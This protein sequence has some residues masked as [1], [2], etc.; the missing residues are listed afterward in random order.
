VGAEFQT[1]YVRRKDMY[2]VLYSYSERGPIRRLPFKSKIRAIR[3]ARIL[4]EAGFR[5]CL[6]SPHPLRFPAGDKGT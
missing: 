2:V 3:A 4:T 5:A 6:L 1:T